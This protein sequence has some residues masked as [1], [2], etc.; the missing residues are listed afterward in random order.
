[1]ILILKILFE[2][3]RQAK[4]SL[5]ANKLRTFLSLIGITIGIFTIVA[6]NSAVDSLQT[7]VK[8]GLAEIG[9]DVV[10]VERFPWNGMSEEQYLKF[11]KRPDVD[12]DDFKAVRERSKLAHLS[13]YIVA[14]GSGTITHRSSSVRGA[15]I[16]APTYEY[17]KI[18]NLE[19]EKGRYF[20]QKEDAEAVNKVILGFG[21][22]KELF[23][24]VEALGKTIKMR[25]NKYVV[26]GVLK[27]E[28]ESMFNF[29]NFDEVAWIPFNTARKFVNVRDGRYERSLVVKPYDGISLDELKS[30]L[31]GI[32][33]A[34]RRLQPKEE[35]NFSLM[36]MSALNNSLDQVF[37]SL[38]WAGRIIGFFALLVGMISV[39]NIMFVSVK[40]RTNQ[41]GIKM[42]I[43]AKK[44]VILW[45]FLIEGIILCIVGGLMGMVL[46]IGVVN[47]VSAVSPFK[48]VFSIYNFIYGLSWSV[49]IGLIAAIIPALQASRLDPVVAIRK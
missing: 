13:S 44:E 34:E 36:E 19:I 18:K 46:V 10:Y 26:I 25:G 14:T 27:E 39:A 17:Q 30:E 12:L 40:E 9:S 24:G 16:I 8:S 41:I 47:I 6:L 38:N 43:G 21:L 3:I 11:L 5:I 22:A 7:N 35:D 45:E 15:T 33:R 48:M 2:G 31:T 32:L 49:G 37:S 4:H 1:M 20:T 23:P 42:A 28:G 29:L